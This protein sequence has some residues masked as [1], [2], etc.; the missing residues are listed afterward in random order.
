MRPKL[1]ILTRMLGVRSQEPPPMSREVLDCTSPLALSD[2]R[3]HTKAPKDWRSPRP[4]GT[5]GRL[6]QIACVCAAAAALLAGCR[7]TT[8]EPVRGA[9]PYGES[10]AKAGTIN[11]ESIGE[12]PLRIPPLTAG[13]R[14]SGNSTLAAP[15]P[16]S[17]GEVWIIARGDSRATAPDQNSPGSGAL[18]AKT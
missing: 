4:G 5:N 14:N 13:L 17:T 18:M 15:L 9:H 12:A 2:V 16:M 7:R 6:F 3:R 8:L 10:W 1:R 11:L